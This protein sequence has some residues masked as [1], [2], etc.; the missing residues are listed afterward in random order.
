[1]T[2]SRVLKHLTTTSLRVGKY[3]PRSSQAAIKTAIRESE[4]NH[5]GEIQ[6]AVEAALHP[7]QV[8]LGMT[9]RKRALDVFAQLRVWDT[10]DNNGILIYVL[11][12]DHAVEIVV[13]RGITVH[14]GSAI[15][16]RIAETIEREF[17]QGR[18]ETGALRGITAIAEALTKHFPATEANPNQLRDDVILL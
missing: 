9:A 14:C 3:F 1:M 12:A 18:F 16:Q 7:W 5:T 6:F 17:A 10:E 15:W 2:F 11:L 13:D 4:K 8:L